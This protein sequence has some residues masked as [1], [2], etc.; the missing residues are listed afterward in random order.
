MAASAALRPRQANT[1]VAC[2]MATSRRA[3]IAD[4]SK[5]PCAM[6]HGSLTD[7]NHLELPLRWRATA[8]ER[9]GRGPTGLPN[10]SSTRQMGDGSASC[11]KKQTASCPQPTQRGR[12]RAHRPRF[13]RT[14]LPRTPLGGASSG[15][16]GPRAPRPQLVR[17]WRVR[18]HLGRRQ[19]TTS[20]A[21]SLIALQWTARRT[22]PDDAPV[23]PERGASASRGASSSANSSRSC[24]VRSARNW[25]RAASQRAEEAASSWLRVSSS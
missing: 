5:P 13:Q 23:R 17:A 3:G 14:A 15:A 16:G 8:R 7:R 19:S 22:A 12:E 4:C 10:G 6:R 1:T 9:R 21:S 2:T 20:C 25:A 24:R 18:H 11:T